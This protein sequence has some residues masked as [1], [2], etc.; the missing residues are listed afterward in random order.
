MKRAYSA[1]TVPFLTAGLVLLI[2]LSCLPCAPAHA[3]STTTADRIAYLGSPRYMAGVT[4]FP[5]LNP[6]VPKG[7]HIRLPAFGTFDTLNPYTVKGVNLTIAS[8]QRMW[9]IDALNETLMAGGTEYLPSPDEES[10]VYC[11]LCKSVTW[12]SGFRWVRF[13]LRPDARFHDGSP[14][15]G[16]DALASFQLLTGQHGLPRFSDAW[17]AVERASSEQGSIT[18][19]LKAG[20]N[21]KTVMKLGE[22]PVMSARFWATR[23]FSKPLLEAPLLSGPYRVGRIQ[24]GVSIELVRV[25]DFW[26]RDHFFYRGQ[27]NFDSVTYDFFRDRTVAFEAFKSGSL[28]AWVEYIAKNWATAYDFPALQKGTIRRA[29]LPHRIPASYQFFALNMRKSPMGLAAFRKALTLAFDFEWTNKSLFND[30]YRRENSYFPNSVWG[31]QSPTPS[32]PEVVLAARLGVRIP[33]GD[34]VMPMTDGSGNDRRH[35]KEAARILRESGFKL[36][37][38][39]LVA[40]DGLPVLLEFLTS[41][42]SFSRVIQPYRRNLTRLGIDTRIRV[43]DDAQFKRRMDRH[44]FDIAVISWPQAMMPGGE[45]R[46]QFHSSQANVVGG[47]NFGGTSNREI[48]LV[49]D[50]IDTVDDREELKNLTSLLDRILMAGYYTIPQWYLGH[51]RI[52]WKSVL[53]GIAP[54]P[55]SL[56]FAAWHMN[57][58]KIEP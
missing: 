45:L 51:H 19:Q 52:A 26:S 30:A 47:Y 22:L 54:P 11:L 25:S 44:E 42:A 17:R 29:T 36:T 1:A 28:D 48:D 23:D 27:Y 56:G 43:V 37:E 41:Q 35:I 49:L 12:D 34:V 38:G 16:Q 55:Y 57:K 8:D 39:K 3:G 21:L 6:D 4:H 24:P 15:T 5:W 10:V 14:I 31:R 58:Q 2:A 7:G 20:A 53:T 32:E 46:L 33:A 18:F 9:G 40:P 50:A 13:D